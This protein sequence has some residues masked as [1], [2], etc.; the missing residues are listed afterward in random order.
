MNTQKLTQSEIL[1]QFSEVTVFSELIKKL[2]LQSQKS[3]EVVCQ[4]IINGV[5]FT[6]VDE[7]KFAQQSTAEIQMIEIFTRRP[8]EILTEVIDNWILEIPKMIRLNDQLAQEVRFN[9]LQGQLKRLVDL[10]DHSQLLIDSIISMG[11]LFE[12][13]STVRSEEWQRAQRSSCDSVSE[14]LLAFQKKDFNLLADVLEYDLGHA[15]QSW[16]DLFSI[17]RE[18]NRVNDLSQGPREMQ[19]EGSINAGNAPKKDSTAL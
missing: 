15:L 5:P 1:A 17:I 2:E 14:A 12:N 10:I 16:L 7:A 11:T 8:D 13:L 18:E 4:I 3:G 19:G 9:G 6:E